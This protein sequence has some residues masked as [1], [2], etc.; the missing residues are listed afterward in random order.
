MIYR[1]ITATLLAQGA[2]A[3]GRQLM[4]CNTSDIA[5]CFANVANGADI[6]LVPGKMNTWDGLHSTIQLALFSK[7]LSIACSEDGGVCVWQGATGKRV[8]YITDNG[9]TSTLSHLVI[10]DGDIN[11]GS[12]NGGGLVVMNSNVVLILVAFIDN[13]ASNRGGAIYVDSSSS[14]TVTLQGC[15]FAGNTASY[16]PDVSNN[17]MTV[18]ISGCPAGEDKPTLSPLHLSPPSLIPPPLPP[19]PLLSSQV[20]LKSKVPP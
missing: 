12:G 18:V 5:A 7:Y 1:F 20:I 10:K 9:G 15:S 8:V 6:D 13:A 4:S 16:G 14:H 3:A 2:A 19:S 11:Q 17:G